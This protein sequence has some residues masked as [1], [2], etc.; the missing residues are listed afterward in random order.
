MLHFTEINYHSLFKYIVTLFSKLLRT[1]YV[2]INDNDDFQAISR[3]RNLANEA[4][5]NKICL[6]N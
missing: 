6:G 3:N 2:Y 4:N 1:R 5:K